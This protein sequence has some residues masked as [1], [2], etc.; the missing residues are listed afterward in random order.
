MTILNIH[1]YAGHP[2]NSAYQALQAIGCKNIIAPAID[3][4]TQ[5]PD[6]I[7]EQLEEVI[8]KQ[9]ID[10]IVGTSFG[11]FFAS[12]LSVR[13][14][15]P[16]ILINPCLLP[17]LIEFL[18]HDELLSLIIYFGM[19]SDIDNTKVSCIVGDEDEV[20]GD[21]YF[22]ETLLKNERFRRVPGGKHSGATLPLKEYFKEILFK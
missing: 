7:I 9:K 18:P 19:L 15:L 3:Y 6:S 10:L 5:S 14:N 13:C 12:V 21:H 22:T 2:Q 20:L 11:G 4:D 17:F 1:G 8:N 16:V